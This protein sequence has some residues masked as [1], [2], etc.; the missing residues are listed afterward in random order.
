MKK[1]WQIVSRK[2]I[3]FLSLLFVIVVIISIVQGTNL[4]TVNFGEDS[5]D[6]QSKK[7]SMNIPYDM[8]VSAEL[9]D[10]PAAGERIEG[11]DDM[12]LRIGHWEN[13][14]W[15]EYYVCANLN[16][17]N[18]VAVHLNDGRIFVFSYKSNAKT[19][20]ACQM[21]LDRIGK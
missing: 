5:V 20:E 4:V 11:N 1:F 15:G 17:T 19:A 12:T 3:K 10:M 18:C 8:V 16:C 21:L 9:M 7:Y 13:E 14:T 6:I 2:D